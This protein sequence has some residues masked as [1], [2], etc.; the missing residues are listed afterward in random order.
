MGHIA[1]TASSLQ[2]LI[3]TVGGALIGFAIGQQFNGT[4]V[5]MV[6]GFVLCGA[7][8]LLIASWANPKLP[9]EP[10]TGG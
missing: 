6:A 8:A 5:P 10:V 3:T 1:G 4:T 7:L 9:P 2:G